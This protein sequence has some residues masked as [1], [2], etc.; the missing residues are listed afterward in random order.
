[1]VFSHSDSFLLSGPRYGRGYVAIL[2]AIPPPFWGIPYARGYV[3]VLAPPTLSDLIRR[4]LCG[5]F[6]SCLRSEPE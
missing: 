4:G 5:D 1:M 2:Y 3:P 6:D